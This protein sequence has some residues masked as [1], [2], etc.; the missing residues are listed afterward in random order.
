MKIIHRPLSLV[1]AALDL[2]QLSC[3]SR[4][5][6]SSACCSLLD[7]TIRQADSCS[8]RGPLS[9]RFVSHILDLTVIRKGLP[10]KPAAHAAISDTLELAR[11]I[12]SS[13]AQL[14]SRSQFTSRL[15]QVPKE[16]AWLS[17]SL[18]SHEHRTHTPAAE[19]S[20]LGM[21]HS[22]WKTPS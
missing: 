13:L 21:P 5:V 19:S 7:N 2:C 8:Y 6:L 11:P 16:A 15:I 12:H 4:P 10:S 9:S 20:C 1:S 17:G 14:S 22:P 18:I 3:H